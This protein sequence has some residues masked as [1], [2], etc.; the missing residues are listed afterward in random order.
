MIQPR[1]GDCPFAFYG[2]RRNAQDFGDLLAVQPHE[3]AHLHDVALFGIEPLQSI[4]CLIDLEDV[5]VGLHRYSK[6]LVQTKRVGAL[7]A[8]ERPVLAGV[9]HQYLAHHT[10]ANRE[11]MRPVLVLLGMHCDQPEIGLVR[12]RCRLQSMARPF[13]PEVKLGQP[14][15]FGIDQRD[16]RLESLRLPSTPAGEQYGYLVGLH[17]LAANSLPDVLR[18]VSCER[19]GVRDA[20]MTAKPNAEKTSRNLKIRLL[21]PASQSRPTSISEGHSQ[22]VQ[23]LCI[24]VHPG[25]LLLSDII[26]RPRMDTD[27]HG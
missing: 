13:T 12:Q 27:A 16:E 14:A 8:L 15:Q 23:Y 21:Q 4:E 18:S 17:G 26:N 22:D 20:K 1:L 19:V 11:E 5:D 9:I 25:P 3:E 10:R 7:V 6:G 2:N 24:C